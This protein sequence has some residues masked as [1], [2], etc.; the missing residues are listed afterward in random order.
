MKKVHLISRRNSESKKLGLEPVFHDNV[1]ICDSSF[2]I[3]TEVGHDVT[4]RE[5]ELGDYSYISEYC[6]I[7]Y[8]T[9]GKFTSIASFVRINPGNHPM[10]RITQHHMTYRRSKYGFG[11]DDE[12]FFNRRRDKW[13][14]VGHDV[15]I[16]HGVTI[17]AGVKIGNGSVIGAGSVVTKDIPPYSLAVGVPAKVIRKRFTDEEIRII[18]ESKWWEWSYEKIKENFNLLVNKEKFI[19]YMKTQG[20]IK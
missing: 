5:M 17:T 18:E 7:I 4:L 14:H 1:D 8:T 10:E 19:E 2:G 9:I 6:D 13:C 15:W 11:E 12:E 20:G 16:G 3:Y